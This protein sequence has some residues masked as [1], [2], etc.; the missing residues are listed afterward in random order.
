[1]LDY[2]NSVRPICQGLFSYISNKITVLYYTNEFLYIPYIS[3]LIENLRCGIK[4]HIVLIYLAIGLRRSTQ[5]A[6]GEAL[7]KL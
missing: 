4:K 6:E 1:M 3:K 5:E 7:L 2:S